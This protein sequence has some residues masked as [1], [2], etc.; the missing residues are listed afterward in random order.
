MFAKSTGVSVSTLALLIGSAWLGLAMPGD[1]QTISSSEIPNTAIRGADAGAKRDSISNWVPVRFVPRPPGSPDQAGS[2]RSDRVAGER[3]KTSVAKAA[4][5]M[6]RSAPFVEQPPNS[7]KKSDRPLPVIRLTDHNP[8]GLQSTTAAQPPVRFV[9]PVASGVTMRLSDGPVAEVDSPDESSRRGKWNQLATRI[10]TDATRLSAK[11]STQPRPRQAIARF[12]GPTSRSSRNR[13]HKKLQLRK[14]TLDASAELALQLPPEDTNDIVRESHGKAVVEFVANA[15][16]GTGKQTSVATH[17]SSETQADVSETSAVAGA[18]ADAMADAMAGPLNEK[19]AV[20][21]KDISDADLLVADWDAVPAAPTPLTLSLPP[22]PS[23]FT[24]SELK[25]VSKDLSKRGLVVSDSAVVPAAFQDEGFREV[26]AADTLPAPNGNRGPTGID[27]EF[28]EPPEL[29]A[30]AGAVEVAPTPEIEAI[31]TDLTPLP[32]RSTDDLAADGI[33]KEGRTGNQSGNSEDATATGRR[34]S[35]EQERPISSLTL[36]ISPRLPRG[37]A[38]TRRMP[39]NYAAEKFGSLDSAM[40]GTTGKSWETTPVAWVAPN[41]FHGPLLFEDPTLE[42]YGHY[43]HGDL[44]QSVIS[45]AHFFLGT[46]LIPYK[47]G[48]MDS[49]QR[50]YTLGHRLPGECVPFH[51]YR[52][53]RS[54]RGLGLTALTAGGLIWLIP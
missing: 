10:E 43:R 32:S 18:M 49:C 50:T 47:V 48:S 7:G 2:T 35:I 45:S 46:A 22:Q 12:E 41:F 4:P 40:Y 51:S 36:D 1:A 19:E 38:G 20:A 21:E 9:A 34:L 28:A 14:S 54:A 37:G 8:A 26:D 30:D 13:L 17:T 44:A 52:P 33:S 16:N 15:A 24:P 29:S 6:P 23:S 25:L 5:A 39:T 42:R 3:A 27:E 31:E 53:V 11:R